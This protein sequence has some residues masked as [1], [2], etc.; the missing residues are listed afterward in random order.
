MAYH[1]VVHTEKRLVRRRP[2][3]NTTKAWSGVDSDHL[4]R[5]GLRLE[6]ASTDLQNF[7]RIGFI[8]RE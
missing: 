3:V 8:C 7:R 4:A 6:D 5:R 1:S 2:R